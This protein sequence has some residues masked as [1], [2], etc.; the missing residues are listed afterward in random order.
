MV[1]VVVLAEEAVG[2]GGDRGRGG[3]GDEYCVGRCC[4]GKREVAVGWSSGKVGVVAVV[5]WMGANLVV[6]SVGSVAVAWW[7]R[8][9]R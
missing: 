7:S 8:W 4:D 9:W 6:E 2:D 3:G 1:I 5:V